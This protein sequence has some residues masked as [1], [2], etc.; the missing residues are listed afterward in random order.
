M[1]KKMAPNDRIARVDASLSRQLGESLANARLTK[2]IAALRGALEAIKRAND[3]EQ[4][5]TALHN[6]QKE[7]TITELYAFLSQDETG[8]GICEV[9]L[10][11]E[12]MTLVTSRAHIAELMKPAAVHLAKISGRPVRLVKFTV[13]EEVWDTPYPPR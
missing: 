10:G 1:M 5:M 8:D 12:W 2:R 9:C 7:A 3:V 13:R 11:D 4:A 6:S